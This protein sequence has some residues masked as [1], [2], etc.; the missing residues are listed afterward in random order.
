MKNAKHA[1]E[2]KSLH[3]RLTKDMKPEPHEPVDALKY[4]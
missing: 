2:L 4:G 1:E 3:K